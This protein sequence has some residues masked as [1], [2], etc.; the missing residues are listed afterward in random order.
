MFGTKNSFL[1]FC[2]CHLLFYLQKKRYQNSRN[3]GEC[4][5]LICIS[6]CQW[7]YVCLD[8][9]DSPDHHCLINKQEHLISVNQKRLFGENMMKFLI[10]IVDNYKWL[11]GLYM[12]ANFKVHFFPTHVNFFLHWEIDLVHTNL[13]LQWFSLK[14]WIC[15]EKDN[16]L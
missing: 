11:K 9:Q 5:I 3:L 7:V 14:W 1:F 10:L 15:E 2:R 12:I 13:P 6:S 8:V 4:F 16:Y